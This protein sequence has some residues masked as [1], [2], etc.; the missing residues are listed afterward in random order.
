MVRLTALTSAVFTLPGNTPGTHFCHRLSQPQGHSAAGRIM[1]MK[2]SSDIIGNRTRDLPA[3]SAVPQPTL[4]PCAPN[5]YRY[6]Q[7]HGRYLKALPPRYPSECRHYFNRRLN[8]TD[9]KLCFIW[10]A[11]EICSTSS[12]PC[13]YIKY[14][15]CD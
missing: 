3:S 1:A 15:L 4:P 2:N 10:Q 8:L 5:N 12:G 7:Y 6:N 13:R 11:Y 9:S 14:L